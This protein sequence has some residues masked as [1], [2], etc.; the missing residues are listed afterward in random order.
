MDLREFEKLIDACLENMAGNKIQL[1][2][3]MIG[4]TNKKVNQIETKVEEMD[5]LRK[6]F[7]EDR[8]LLQE[9]QKQ[10]QNNLSNLQQQNAH[11][12]ISMP[13]TTG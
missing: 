12:A 11:N 2:V 8:K 7:Y 10:P 4:N 3:N 5:Q 13:P 6:D 9:Q 1:L